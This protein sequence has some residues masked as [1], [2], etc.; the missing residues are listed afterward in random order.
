[1]EI[2]LQL[3]ITLWFVIDYRELVFDSGKALSSTESF[4]TGL[5][6]SIL[7]SMVW[8]I[9]NRLVYL[10]QNI[11]IKFWLHFA[12]CTLYVVLVFLLVPLTDTRSYMLS[13]IHI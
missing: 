2:F 7:S 4:G 9:L 6:I 5:T 3:C 12:Q 10:S 1:M 8:I 11:R 13:L